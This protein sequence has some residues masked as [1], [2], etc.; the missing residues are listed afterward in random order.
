MRQLLHQLFPLAVNLRRCQ[1]LHPAESKR[2]KHEIRNSGSFA[3]SCHGTPNQTKSSKSF[4]FATNLFHLSTTMSFWIMLETKK[5]NL[6]QNISRTVGKVLIN[7]LSSL[8]NICPKRKFVY[9][10]NVQSNKNIVKSTF[11][12]SLQIDSYLLQSASTL[13]QILT[14]HV[15]QFA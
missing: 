14:F 12:L 2:T 15:F 13:L 7:H 11:L 8:L 5:I 9:K 10:F 6:I 3:M 1:N 4:S